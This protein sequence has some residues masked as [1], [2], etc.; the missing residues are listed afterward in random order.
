LLALNAYYF[1]PLFMCENSTH[2]PIVFQFPF[3]SYLVGVFSILANILNHHFRISFK[4][5]LFPMIW[6][7]MKNEVPYFSILP[8][9]FQ[10]EQCRV[11][12]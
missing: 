12:G 10:R 2:S 3:I 11:E 9:Q 4:F 7:K 8:K 1:S 5:L 6:K